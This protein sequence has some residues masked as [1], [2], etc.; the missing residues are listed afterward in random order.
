LHTELTERVSIDRC[1]CRYS[2][3]LLQLSVDGPNQLE[4]RLPHSTSRCKATVL[5]KTP[6]RYSAKMS[7]SRAFTTRR[8]VKTADVTPDMPR[9]NLTTKRSFASGTIR[10]K[11][12]A[13][14]ELVSTTN[15]LSYNAPDIYPSLASS[16]ASSHSGTD[17]ERSPSSVSTPFTSPDNSSIEGSP[18]SLE[19]NHLSC[20]FG[21]PSRQ[22]NSDN[23]APL[24]P[25]RAPSHNKKD[26][27]ARSASR[28]SAKTHQSTSTARSSINMF[29]ANP[30]TMDMHPPQP[31]HPFGNELAQVS[32]L[33]EEYGISKERLAVVDEEEQEL[34]SKGLFKF[35]A[36]DYMSEIQ[37]LFIQAFGESRPTMAS[38][39]I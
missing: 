12:S 35:R 11:I 30:E 31:Q 7:L 14:L 4:S 36:E 38:M 18:T 15:M 22:S 1:S 33:A 9:R 28:M 29:A 24:I 26:S 6:P 13:P 39:W 5:I 17:S 27:L 19:P 37:G 2:D 23:E 20:Y 32:E 16:S 8:S 3:H 21:V 10:H 34:V 25:K